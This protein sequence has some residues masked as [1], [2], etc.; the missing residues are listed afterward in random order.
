MLKYYI[1]VSFRPFTKTLN[2]FFYLSSAKESLETYMQVRFEAILIKTILR[3]FHWVIF[4]QMQI[5]SKKEN[6]MFVENYYM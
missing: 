3:Y 2:Q 1:I 4:K 6:I 5:I